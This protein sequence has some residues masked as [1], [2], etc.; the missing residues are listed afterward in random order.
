MFLNE[1]IR[2]ITCEKG[3]TIRGIYNLLDYLR[4]SQDL[5]SYVKC[6]LYALDWH[7][8]FKDNKMLG[9]NLFENILTKIVKFIY[10][11][12][13]SW[14]EGTSQWGRATP[15]VKKIHHWHVIHG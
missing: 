8:F 7:T 10:F 1:S 11:C 15:R 9:K 13:G 6:L 14:S 3:R 2:N 4:R 5:I 12:Y